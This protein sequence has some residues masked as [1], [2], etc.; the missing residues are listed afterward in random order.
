VPIVLTTNKPFK[1][2]LAIFNNDST[3]TSAILGR[4]LHHAETVSIEGE[5]YRR[6]E[7]IE[8]A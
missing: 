3:V 2:W 5:S 1:T 8:P 7:R 6:K 4:L